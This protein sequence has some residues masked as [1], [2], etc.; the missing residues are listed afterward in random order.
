MKDG[1]GR[2]IYYL[3]LSVTDLCNLRCVYCMPAGGVEKRRHEDVLTVEELE[4]IAR[5]A[6]RCGIRKIRLTGGEPLVRRGIVDICARTA[7]APGVEEVCMTTNGLLLPKLA[8]ELRKAGLRRVNI[9]LDTLS[10]ELYRE[11]TRVGNIEDAVSGLKAALDNFET[12]KIN[13]VL[14]GGTNEPEIRQ[15]VYITKD[16]PVELR[17]IELMPI[18]ECAH[19]PRERFLENSAVLEAVPELEPCGTS[20]VARLFSLPN[21]RGRVGLISPLSSHFCPECNRIRITPDG[22]LKPC[23]HSAQEIELRG[24]HGAEL[25]AKLREGICAKPMRHH[26]SPASPSES[27]RGMSQIGG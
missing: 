19:W 2:D 9:S 22:R 6:G 17:F 7:A 1:Y 13:A 10:P 16:A 26:L 20:G 4:E 12:V 27:L 23:L 15:M 8:P 24:F 25:D 3:R 5:S 14:I 21:A 18:G 11:L